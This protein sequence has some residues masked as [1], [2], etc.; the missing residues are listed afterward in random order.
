MRELLEDDGHCRL[1]THNGHR[2][3]ACLLHLPD[4]VADD[5]GAVTDPSAR[6]YGVEGLRVCDASIMPRVPRANYQFPDHDDG[7]ESGGYDFVG[8]QPFRVDAAISSTSTRKFGSA[9][10]RRSAGSTWGGF[11]EIIGTHRV[12]GG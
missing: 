10:R 5:P 3:L 1:G 9:S 12:V 7:R 4:G 2:S 6:V 8:A 11:A